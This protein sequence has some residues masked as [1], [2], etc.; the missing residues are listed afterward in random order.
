MTHVGELYQLECVAHLTEENASGSL[1]TPQARD[2]K[3]YTRKKEY[4]YKRAKIKVCIANFLVLAG[5]PKDKDGFWGKFHPQCSEMLMAWPIEWTDLKP[6]EMDK[7]QEWR[8]QHSDFLQN[9]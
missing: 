8:Q 3:E 1:P 2:H 9:Q 4:H 6:L 5:L 7:F